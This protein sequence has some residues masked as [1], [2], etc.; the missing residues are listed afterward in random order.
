MCVQIPLDG[1]P[2]FCYVDCM[3]QLG[4]ISKLAEVTLI[5]E[6]DSEIKLLKST[7]PKT[8]PWGSLLVTSC[9]LG[10]ELLTTTLWLGLSNQLFI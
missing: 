5:S 7:F 2:P 1:I 10:I 3:T 6:K 9:H 8:N 4:A